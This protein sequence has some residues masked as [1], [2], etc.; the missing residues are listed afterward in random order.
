MKKQKPSI[1]NDV[2]GPIMRGPSSS[3]VAAAARIGEIVRQSVNS[4]IK[5][6]VCDFDVNGSLAE[7]HDGHGTDMGFACGILGIPLTDPRVDQ[8]R[9]LVPENG[10][11]LEYR[12]L[13]Y[14]VEHPNYYRIE[15]TSGTG[16]VVHIDAISTGGGMIDIIKLEAPSTSFAHCS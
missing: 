2:I 4:D 8:Y 3:H 1:F 7:S 14:G 10:I 5:K 6:I 13:D 12:I 9:T 16:K 11:D 15:V